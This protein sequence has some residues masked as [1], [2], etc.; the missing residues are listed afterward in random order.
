MNYK[1]KKRLSIIL[2]LSLLLQIAQFYAFAFDTSKNEDVAKLFTSDEALQP[3]S[4]IPAVVCEVENKRDTCKKEFLLEDGSFCSVITSF[5]IH[6]YAEGKWFEK[7]DINKTCSIESIV[8]NIQNL[9]NTESESR[10][11]ESR[12][13]ETLEESNGLIV[14]WG[15]TTPETINGIEWHNLQTASV[16]YT[17]LNS[18]GTYISNDYLV[19][20][21]FLSVDCRLLSENGTT[22]KLYPITSWNTNNMSINNQ[23]ILCERSITSGGSYSFNITDIFNKWERGQENNSGIAFS[24]NNKRR[25]SASNPCIIVRYIDADSAELDFTY[26]SLD[27]NNSG[28]AYI[29]DVTNNYTLKQ[30]LLNYKYN[31]TDLSIYRTYDSAASDVNNYSGF[32]STFNFE[33]KL[34]VYS[35]YA[36]WTMFDGNTI[37]FAP[38]DPVTTNSGYEIWELLPTAGSANINAALYLPL[39]ESTGLVRYVSINGLKYSFKSD[40]SIEQIYDMST[41]ASIMHFIYSP[42][43]SNRVDIIEMQNGNSISFE[44]DPNSGLICSVELQDENNQTVTINNEQKKTEI[45]FE[46]INGQKINTVTF[47]NGTESVYCFDSYGHL[48]STFNENSIRCEFEYAEYPDQSLGSFIVGYELFNGNSSV[49]LKSLTIDADNTFKRVFTDIDGKEEI[50]YYNSDYRIITYVGPDGKYK[51]IDYDETGLVNSYVFCKDGTELVI[52]NDFPELDLEPW[53]SYEDDDY[54]YA[55][56]EDNPTEDGT[57]VKLGDTQGNNTVILYQDIVEE[58]EGPQIVFEADKTYVFGGR[59]YLDNVLPDLD[60]EITIIIETAPIVNGIPSTNYTEYARLVFDNTLMLEWQYRLK[61]FKLEE[62]SVLRISLNFI[63]QNKFAYF[64]DITLFESQESGTDIDDMVTSYPI[65]Y[66]YSNDGRHVTSETLTWERPNETDLTMSTEYS[67]DSSNKLQEYVDFNGNSTYYRYNSRTGE[68]SGKGH[69]IENNVITDVKSLQKDASSLLKNVEQ[70]IKNVETNANVTLGVEYYNV[71]GRVEEVKHNG[72]S[73]IF[74]YNPDGSLAET[75]TDSDAL[76]SNTNDEY[77]ME[78][79]YANGELSVIDYSNGYRIKYLTGTNNQGNST[80]TIGCYYVSGEN[81]TLIKSYLYTFDDEQNL[82]SVYDSGSDLTITYTDLDSYE[83]SDYGMLYQKTS[84]LDN[85]ITESY[86]QRNYVNAQSTSTDIVETTDTEITC[87]SDGTNSINSSIDVSK[88]IYY[89]VN[90]GGVNTIYYHGYYD[91]D[92]ESIRDYFG[93]ISSK[94]V[95]TITQRG[96]V[97]NSL[98]SKAEYEYLNLGNGRTSSLVSD[99]A[100]SFYTPNNGSTVTTHQTYNRKYEYDNKG[101]IIFVYEVSGNN[102]DPMQYYE[103]DSAN[104]IITE[105]DF[106]CQMSAHYTYNSGGNLVAKIYYDFSDLS[107]NVTNRQIV[108]LGQEIRRVSFQYDSVWKDRL[109]VYSDTGF[110]DDN[111]NDSVYETITYDKMGNPLKYVGDNTLSLAHYS[112][113]IRT[114][115][116]IIIGDLEWNGNRLVSFE[117]DRNRYEYNY[118]ANGYR[119]SK[120]VFNKVTENNT[121]VYNKASIIDYIWNNGVLTG[122]LISGVDSLGQREGTETAIIVYDQEGTPTGY[123]SLFGVPYLFKKDLNENVLSLVFSDGTNIC[124]VKYDSWG[125]PQL[126]L[127]G[128]LIQQIISVVTISYC[129]SL[130]H[131]YLYDYETGMYFNQGKCYS[132]SWGRY[133][134]PESPEILTERNDNPLDSN[135]Y[136]FCNNN[137]VN[138]LDKVASWS[139]EYTGIEWKSNGFEVAMSDIFASRSICTIFAAQIIKVYGTWNMD[140]GYNYMGLSVEDIASDLFAHYVGR[141]AKGAVN[142]V[143]AVW[144]DGWILKNSQSD[145]IFVCREDPNLNDLDRKGKYYKIWIAAPEIKAYAQKDGVFITL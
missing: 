105:I 120:C 6:E 73:H 70:I 69:T 55:S 132:S 84:N 71:S 52:E 92:R 46:T 53:I 126:T 25:L 90:A 33:S 95:D 4:R 145:K 75:Y 108:S 17:K 22:S 67:Y 19:T 34:T 14:D 10:Q 81:E 26:H 62:D 114:L 121:I 116:R 74:A 111:V 54:E 117:T 20:S 107:F 65:E 29:N 112:D 129:P 143:N 138:T 110:I 76:L 106:E 3:V 15:N 136:L 123:L 78:Y 57:A 60:R 48:L 23:R 80:K 7:Y 44:Y 100:Q 88:N 125:S 103:Y 42:S 91:Y 118:D 102:I 85:S 21:A 72:Y 130:Y 83:I 99:Y 50:I 39:P 141:T 101:N 134:S 87:N 47:A 127:Y 18:V 45:E 140:Y 36:V 82:L 51:C 122:L 119:T 31:K 77:N 41:N 32:K 98:S 139:R 30:E 66:T 11:G 93:R 133:I 135:L 58:E 9:N 35:N 96:S 2:M 49:A 64:T 59:V 109:T 37:R 86:G 128:D 94:T 43:I 131:G 79:T 8:Q 1:I 124:S 13:E 16:F 56:Q 12:S 142:K 61:A 40:G 24:V 115:D 97:P 68:L 63:N 38:T 5:P 89:S 104:Q 113:D 137:P 28:Q 27:L 144:G